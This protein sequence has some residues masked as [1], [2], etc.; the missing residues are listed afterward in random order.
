ML[1]AWSASASDLYWYAWSDNLE[2]CVVLIKDYGQL[3]N[4]EDTKYL[5]TVVLTLIAFASD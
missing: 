1:V 2:L 4:L 5:D 3:V